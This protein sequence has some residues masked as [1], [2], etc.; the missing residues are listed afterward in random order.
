MHLGKSSN[1]GWIALKEI[2]LQKGLNRKKIQLGRKVIES[3]SKFRDV[4]EVGHDVVFRRRRLSDNADLKLL[5]KLF[6]CVLS[7]FIEETGELSEDGYMEF[8]ILIQRALLGNQFTDAEMVKLAD[9]DY[10]Y[11]IE[12]FG[13]MSETTFNDVLCELVGEHIYTGSY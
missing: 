4:E 8:D 13:S 7:V 11:D 10:R 5:L 3:S 1:K 2:Y 12:R 6:W 9:A